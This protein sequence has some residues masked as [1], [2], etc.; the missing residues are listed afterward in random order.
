VKKTARSAP[1]RPRAD[2]RRTARGKAT[3]AAPAPA[4]APAGQLYILRLFVTGTSPRSSA[5]I[6]TIR[7]ICD[8]YLKDNYELEVVDLY[9]R[10]SAAVG[11]QIVAAP[12]LVKQRPEPVRRLIGTLAD[13]PR[14][15][16]GLDII[17]G[18]AS[19]PAPIPVRRKGA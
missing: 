16:R 4:P 2:R 14:V 6:A 7:S 5:A 19:P 13:R 17:N 3:T 15:L 9:Q 8:E 11:E 10:P 1:R 18:E 12:T